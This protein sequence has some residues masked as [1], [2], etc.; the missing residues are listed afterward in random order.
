MP[1]LTERDAKKLSPEQATALVRVSTYRRSGTACWRTSGQRDRR[2]PRPAEG[3]RRVPGGA[4]GLQ[5]EYPG[6][7]VP[8]PTQAIPERLAV[9]CRVLRT[10]FGKAEGGSP[11]EVMAKVYRLADRIAARLSKE[12]V[13]RTP[14][15]DLAGA[16][17]ELDVVIAWCDALVAHAAQTVEGRGR[18]AHRF[19]PLL[20]LLSH[21]LAN[22][23]RGTATSSRLRRL[24]SETSSRPCPPASPA[25]PPVFLRRRA[26]D[27]VR[28]Q[29]SAVRS[30]AGEPG[31]PCT[32]MVRLGSGS[33]SKEPKASC[34]PGTSR[35]RPSSTIKC[36]ESPAAFLAV[37]TVRC[38]LALPPSRRAGVDPSCV[39]N[40]C[41]PCGSQPGPRTRS[42]SARASR[43]WVRK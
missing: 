17:R 12:P 34:R 8:E 36:R 32:S 29:T 19:R 22:N 26:D 16:V 18:V 3:Q 20:P 15:T 2:P 41:M 35:G 33:V 11:A 13:A 10:V 28:I 9:W 40:E 37:M 25:P 31:R 1:Q 23:N 27:P 30:G 5:A 43:Y 42:A 7:D 38:A 4:P 6:A 24:P 21:L 39:T 14:A